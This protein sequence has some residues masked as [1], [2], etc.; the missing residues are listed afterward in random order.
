[1]QNSLKLVGI[2]FMRYASEHA[3]AVTC[4]I[5]TAPA[6]AMLH[7]LNHHLRI[8][9]HLHTITSSLPARYDIIVNRV[10]TRHYQVRH[11]SD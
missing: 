9:Q 3:G 11:H 1:M 8:S 4:I 7:T 10:D 5:V 2:E 6:T